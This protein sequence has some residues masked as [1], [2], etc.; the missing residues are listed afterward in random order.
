MTAQILGRTQFREP[1]AGW[2]WPS[3]PSP[4]LEPYGD[5]LKVSASPQETLKIDGPGVHTRNGDSIELR[6]RRLEPGPGSV[7]FGFDADTHEFARAEIDFQDTALSFVTNDWTNS[8]PVASAPLTVSVGESHVIL[9]EKQ[10]G[11]GNLVKNADVRVYFDGEQVL[12]MHGLNLLPEM[13]VN[14]SVGGTQLVIEEFTHRGNPSGMPEDL[15]IGGWQKLNVESIE[16]N[17][18]S[19]CRG[20]VQAA[21]QGVQLLVT[22]ETSLTGLFPRSP[23]TTSPAAVDTAERKLR[24]FIRDLEDAP[25]LVAGLPVWQSVSGHAVE[26]TRY[27]VSRV[28]DPDGEIVSSHAKFHS[29]ELDFWHGYRL[30][31]FEVLGV[32]MSLHIC[33]DG[34]YPETWL[35]PVMFG[36]RLVLHPSMGSSPSYGGYEKGSVD[37]FE[38]GAKHDSGTTHAFHMNVNGGG[39]SYIVGPLRDGPVLAASRESRR[40]NTAFPMVGK[41]QESLFH[42]RIRVDDAFGYW[43]TRSFRASEAAAEAYLSLYRT[44]GG[45]TE[46]G[47]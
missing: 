33:H 12:T 6:F 17:L 13:A 5:G 36:A 37:A 34:R 38:A 3:T 8:Q 41:P 15:H 10:E 29:A 23:V 22:P 2:V 26:S 30:N 32:P 47:F 14:I 19:L 20:L 43:P 45:R 7:T 39:G 46:A 11:N 35:L 44:L 31:E 24:R 42:A 1:T 28:Y 25:Y 18:D 4:S 16:E 27:N 9:L 21:E 40:D